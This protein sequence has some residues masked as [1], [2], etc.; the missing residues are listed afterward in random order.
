MLLVL[1]VHYL[2]YEVTVQ[3]PG[4]G[5]AN[6]FYINGIEQANLVLYRGFTTN[7]R[8]NMVAINQSHYVYYNL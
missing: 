1:K 6:R 2:L 3:S 5:L 8:N 4:S 7:F